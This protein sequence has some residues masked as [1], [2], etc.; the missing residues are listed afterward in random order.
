MAKSKKAGRQ[1]RPNLRTIAEYVDLSPTTVS[2]ALRGD[3]SIPSETRERVLAAAEKLNYE[4]VP[5][6]KK[7]AKVQL[8]RLAFVMPDYGDRPV[9]ANPFYGHILSSTEQVCREQHVSLSFVIV[10]HDHSLATSL[11]PVLTHDVDGIL[12]SSP[13]PPA[14]IRRVSRESDCPVV[15]IDNFF[16]GSLYDSVMVDDFGGAYQITN[17]LLELGH[18]QIAM[19][20]G[21]AQ[22]LE[23]I[24]SFQERYRGYSM[25]CAKAN[26]ATFA[27]IVVPASVD[28]QPEINLDALTKWVKE[29]MTRFPQV[30]AFF[31]ISDRFSI[32]LLTAL[33][34][35]G[36]SVPEDL[37]VVGFDDVPQAGISQ[38]RLTTI[39]SFRDNLAQ[40]A[41]E[42]LLARINGDDSPPRYVNLGTK[43]IVRASTGPPPESQK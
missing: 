23:S 24:P 3:E 6:A 11:P 37:S 43:L 27:P 2:L 39:H 13:Y 16:P 22:D 26:V 30:T 32:A 7:S 41:V 35:L 18:T 19:L 38:P 28:P 8:R 17:H 42:Y 21:Y 12:L 4:Y 34:G 9:T 20:T 31:G 15:L 40:L 29:L 25:A 1:T 36:V 14:L 5:R 10:Q 33:N